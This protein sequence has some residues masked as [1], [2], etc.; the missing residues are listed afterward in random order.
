MPLCL[1]WCSCSGVGEVSEQTLRC[2][3]SAFWCSQDAAV[4]YCNR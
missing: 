4:T 1:P 3:G 2:W